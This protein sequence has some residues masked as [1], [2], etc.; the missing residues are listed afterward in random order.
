MGGREGR[1]RS[2]SPLRVSERADVHPLEKSRAV[3]SELL[4]D[5]KKD[6]LP[7]LGRPQ[8]AERF[9]QARHREMEQHPERYD[10]F[11]GKVDSA[12]GEG[13]DDLDLASLLRKEEEKSR[14][15]S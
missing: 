5:F 2:R 10:R 13:D 14:G 1:F 7:Y 9:C 3:F 6:I 4:E 12:G 8:F 11:P 15:G